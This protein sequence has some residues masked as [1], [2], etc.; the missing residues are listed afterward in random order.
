[1]RKHL[2][3]M[4][5]IVFMGVSA[6]HGAEKNMLHVVYTQ[7]EP[8]TYQEN[9]KDSGFEIETVRAVIGKMGLG[10]KFEQLPWKRCLLAMENGQADVLVSALKTPEREK[11]LYYKPLNVKNSYTTRMN[12]SAY[13]RPFF[14]QKREAP[15]S[16]TALLTVLKIIISALSEALVTEMLLIRLFI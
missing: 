14:S 10:S 3:V 13:P 15:Y 12:L 2:A 4:V 8:Y 11:F 16:L 6:G 1:M 7:W 5:M 9:D